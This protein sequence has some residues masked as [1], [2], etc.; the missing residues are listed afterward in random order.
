MRWNTPRSNGWIGSTTAASSSQ[1][2]MC[3]Q[4][5][6]KRSTIVSNP[7]WPSRPDLNPELSGDPGAIQTDKITLSFGTNAVTVTSYISDPNTGG[8]PRTYD[9]SPIQGVNKITSLSALC[10][11]CTTH[12]S[13][14]TFDANGNFASTT[15]HN[16]N[17]T[18]YTF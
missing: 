15:D 9:Y 18:L 4:W 6:S 13:T 1:S 17:Q 5:S 16:G 8:T 12:Y 2:V 14:A 10:P 3:H 11:S 7:V